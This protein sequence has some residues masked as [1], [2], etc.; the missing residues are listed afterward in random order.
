MR[1]LVTAGPSYEPL[2]RVRRL[3]NFSTGALGTALAERLAMAGHEVILLRGVSSTAP[4]PKSQASLR[5]E[6]FSTSSDLAGRVLAHATGDRIAIFHSAAVA[7]FTFGL[8]YERD[9]AGRLSPVL[10]GKVST[11]DGTLLAELRPTPKILAGLREWFPNA[12]IV[13]WKYEVDGS[14]A[15]VLA[16]AQAQLTSSRSDLCVTNGPAWGDGF[17]LVSTA[18]PVPCCADRP[19]LIN[20]LVALTAARAAVAS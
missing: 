20:A 15:T 3:T 13:G 11:R 6:D 16:K 18:E 7:D 10:G 4:L 9:E 5:L 17:G 19:A 2:D 14:H 1:C 8:V 12:W